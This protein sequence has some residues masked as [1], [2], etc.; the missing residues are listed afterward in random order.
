MTMEA[1]RSTKR[2]NFSNS[3]VLEPGWD[4]RAM[5]LQILDQLTIFQ[6]L[7]SDYAHHMDLGAVFQSRP[8]FW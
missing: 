8:Q 2:R 7:G 6:S 4:K 5:A 1:L 3:G